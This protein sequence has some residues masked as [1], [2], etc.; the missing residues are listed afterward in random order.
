PGVGP[1][2]PATPGPA[3][4]AEPKPTKSAETRVVTVP[5]T[6]VPSRA[7]GRPHRG[8]LANGVLL[9]PQGADHVTWDAIEKLSPNRDWRLVGT[10]RLVRTLLTV[11]ASYRR[12]HPGAPRVVIS[13]LSLPQGG[14][15]GP[16]YGGLGH[17]SHQNG[18]DVD[19][20]YP[21][22][23]GQEIGVDR[24][25]QIDRELSQALVDAFVAA[26]AQ[27]VFVG[28]RTRLRGP[29]SVVQK[30]ARHDDHLHLRIPNRR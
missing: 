19:V 4:S 21:R 27:Y 22:A 17:A 30:L 25:G 10:D 29:R 12:A 2:L 6:T 7:L 9:A 24:V 18:L 3:L 11:A 20:A 26:G 16:E 14:S 15:F 28:P 23:D 13:D 5:A 1:R 8:R